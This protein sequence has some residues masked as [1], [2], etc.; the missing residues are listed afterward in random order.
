MLGRSS[1]DSTGGPGAET[2]TLGGGD[3]VTL[4][5]GHEVAYFIRG[6]SAQTVKLRL[7][8]SPL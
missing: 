5:A 3:G 8:Y 4:E 1:G 7:N 2:I 6:E